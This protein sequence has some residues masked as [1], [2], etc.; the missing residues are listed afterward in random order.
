MWILVPGLAWLVALGVLVAFLRT[1]AGRERRRPAII[2]AVVAGLL[3]LGG[4]ALLGIP[5]AVIYGVS[6]PW[7]QLLMGPRYTDLGDGAWP[8]ALLITLTWP[9][10]LLIAYAAANGPL[11]RRGRA[12]RWA[13]LLLIPYLSG[14][15]LALWA[16]LSV[17]E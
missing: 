9:A 2:T 7:V 14:I 10:S 6:A 11:R 12:L 1:P 4:I 15:L 16:H 17:L 3:A 13:A 8:A 5:G